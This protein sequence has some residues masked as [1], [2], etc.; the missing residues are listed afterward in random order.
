M[1]WN[2]RRIVAI[3][4]ALC[5]VIGSFVAGRAAD[6]AEAIGQFTTDSYADT[7]AAIGAVAASGHLMAPRVIGA[8]Q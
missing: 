2:D 3:L 7:E 5:F 4:I 8:L 6:F 1:F